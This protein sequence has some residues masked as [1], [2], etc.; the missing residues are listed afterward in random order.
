M[1]TNGPL[2]NPKVNG[3]APGHVFKSPEGT[4]VKLESELTL[5]TRDPIAY[6]EIIKNGRTAHSISLQEWKDRSGRLPVVDFDE[7][8]WMAIRAVTDHAESYRLAMSGPFYVQIGEEPRIS[9]RAVDFFLE[10]EAERFKRTD[11]SKVI[12]QEAEARFHNA[13]E[14]FWNRLKDKANAP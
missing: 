10:W 3:Q 4:S 6:L 2:M 13:T 9:R 12:P 1:V 11:S 14:T 5:R 7:S 8:G